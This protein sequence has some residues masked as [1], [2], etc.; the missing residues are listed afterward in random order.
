MEEQIIQQLGLNATQTAAYLALLH[1]PTLTPPQLAKVIKVTRTN[2]YELTDQLLEIGLVAREER[3]AKYTFKAKSP[4]A[5]KQLLLQRQQ[6][7]RS[8]SEQLDG[9]LPSLLSTYRLTQD[10]PGVLHLEGKQGLWSLYDDIIRQR[11]EI[12]IFPSAGGR[13]NPE[14]A[15]AIDQ[16]IVRQAEASIPVR[17]LFQH[18]P[19]SP[20][21]AKKQLTK[22]LITARV[23]DGTN[24]PGQIMVYGDNIAMSTFNNGIVTTIITNKELAETMRVI[25]D[26]LWNLGKAI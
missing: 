12:L 18:R 26:V 20:Q 9:I 22:N 15:A 23:V 5:L 2:A 6:E 8:Q 7:L 21:T 4:T 17:A 16:Q 13:D 10:K 25:F 14:I 1:Q 19:Q 11:D 3:G 24:F